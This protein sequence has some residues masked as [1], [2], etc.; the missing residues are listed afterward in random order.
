MKAAPVE[1][2]PWGVPICVLI[3]GMLCV[4]GESLPWQDKMKMSHVNVTEAIERIVCI[5]YL[6]GGTP[7]AKLIEVLSNLMIVRKQ[8]HS[9]NKK[10]A[11]QQYILEALDTLL[12]LKL[13]QITGSEKTFTSIM[14]HLRQLTDGLALFLETNCKIG[15]DTSQMMFNSNAGSETL[16]VEF[17]TQVIEQRIQ[18]VSISDNGNMQPAFKKVLTMGSFV[19]VML[20]TT[21]DVCIITG[22]V[23]CFALYIAGSG[24][25]IIWL[26]Q[27][28]QT[29]LGINN[30]IK[31]K[32]PHDPM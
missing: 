28:Y 2:N 12:K 15:Y 4:Q 24:A 17:L 3:F 26:A 10:F 11:E 23:L 7:H 1:M 6:K 16:A 19:L 30:D 27:I 29:T 32:I 8:L 25:F 22:P 9:I 18:A 13:R 14:M 20:S 21:A 5:L 31:L